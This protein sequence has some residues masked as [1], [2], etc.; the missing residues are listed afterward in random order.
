MLEASHSFLCGP[1][2][3]IRVRLRGGGDGTD[4]PVPGG[5]LRPLPPDPLPSGPLGRSLVSPPFGKLLPPRS[6]QEGG[7]LWEA[8]RGGGRVW[9]VFRGPVRLGI[10]SRSI[11]AQAPVA[12]SYPWGSYRAGVVEML[13]FPFPCKLSLG[14]CVTGGGW[15]VVR[16]GCPTEVVR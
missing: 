10:T 14:S 8:S 12:P 5:G 9:E 1:R 16:G 6:C 13:L 4:P 7:G 15:E 11:T 3:W 2:R